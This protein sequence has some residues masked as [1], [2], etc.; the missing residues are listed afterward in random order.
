MTATMPYSDPMERAV[1]VPDANGGDWFFYDRVRKK[2][3]SVWVHQWDF[4]ENQVL[5]TSGGM[6][7][8][9]NHLFSNSNNSYRVLP[10]D[11]TVVG[12]YVGGNFSLFTGEVGLRDGS[13]FVVSHSFSAATGVVHAADM[14]VD[15]D[16]DRGATGDSSSPKYHGYV[17][18]T[19]GTHMAYLRLL[20]R[21]RLTAWPDG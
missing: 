14:S 17:D 16:L 15:V 21:R 1:F 13:S 11:M 4:G 8:P 19:A 7:A 5:S 20:L 9:G 2:H 6:R 18:R 10:F 12:Y 3:L